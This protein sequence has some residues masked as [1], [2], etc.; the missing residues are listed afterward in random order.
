MRGARSRS[1]GYYGQG[2]LCGGRTENE[3]FAKCLYADKCPEQ[4]G[5]RETN[6]TSTYNLGR[7]EEHIR[8]CV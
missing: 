6:D 1:D 3:E 5:S 2:G 8:E 4:R 7:R